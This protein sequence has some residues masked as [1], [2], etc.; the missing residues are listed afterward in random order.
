MFFNFDIC[1][2]LFLQ[3]ITTP[4]PLSRFTKTN[5]KLSLF[6]DRVR[7]P[8]FPKPF[9][10]SFS[11]VVGKSCKP[12]PVMILGVLIGR[13]RYPALKYLFVLCIVLGVALCMYKDGKTAKTDAAGSLLGKNTRNNVLSSLRSK[14]TEIGSCALTIP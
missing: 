4:C 1:Q 14:R 12:I 7:F 11:Q 5:L 10:I 3:S 2:Q 6:D 13:K 9:N 8:G